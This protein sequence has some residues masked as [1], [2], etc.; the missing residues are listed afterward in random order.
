MDEA[1]RAEALR[2]L[3]GLLALDEP[4]VPVEVVEARLAQVGPMAEKARRLLD[5]LAAAGRLVEVRVDEIV[6]RTVESEA[7]LDEALRAIRG[8]ALAALNDAKV[9]RLR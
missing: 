1:P 9:V 3:T 8:V 4:Q 7:D 5:E 6:R 2:P